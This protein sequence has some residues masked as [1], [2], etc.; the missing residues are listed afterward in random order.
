[1]QTVDYTLVGRKIKEKRLKCG[2][3]QEQ[4][5]ER[6]D[7][8]V[9]YV[10]HIERGTKSLSLE[11]AVRISNVLQISLDALLLDEIREP[12]RIFDALDDE[13]RQCSP[14]QTERFLRLA[15]LLIHHID[16]L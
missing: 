10:A 11:T 3:T 7:I 1:M 12:A 9:S 5:A 14:E 2:M 13:L 15:R 16:E 8:S 6:C 4:L